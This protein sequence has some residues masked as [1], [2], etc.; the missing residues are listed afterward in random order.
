MKGSLVRRVSD[1]S[2]LQRER[3]YEHFNT[4]SFPIAVLASF[5]V[6]L[7]PVTL[8]PAQLPA[9]IG[10]PRFRLEA[11]FCTRAHRPRP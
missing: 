8:E 11:Q 2:P 3:T 7:R 9:A 6:I 5:L 4:I 10:E 1:S